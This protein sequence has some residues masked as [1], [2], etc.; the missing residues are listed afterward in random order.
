MDRKAWGLVVLLAAAGCSAAGGDDG[1]PDGDASEAGDRG[2]SRP[3][4][5]E[6]PP[7]TPPPDDDDGDTIADIDE[8]RAAAVD[9]DRDG[10][11]DYLDLDSDDDTI[12]DSEEAGDDDPR[13]APVD[14]DGDTTPDFRDPDSDGDG[15]SDRDEVAA[16]TDRLRADTDDDGVSDMI[17]VAAGTDPLD[18][19]DNPRA[20]GNFVFVVPYRE[21]PEPPR[22]TLV[23]GTDIQMADVYFAIDR[24]ASMRA[25]LDNL[26]STLRGTI[27]PRVD[28][29]IPDVWF[30]VGTFDQCPMR[31]VCTSSGTPVW[32]RN[33]QNLA[34]DPAATQAALDAMSGTCN[35]ASEPYVST[36]WLLAN[37]DPAR[38]GWDPARV[39]PRNCP[40]AGT[41]IGYP[42]FRAGAIPIV[43]MFGDEDFY[44]QSN[45]AGCNPTTGDAPAVADAIA[46]MNRIGARFIGINSGSS[47]AGFE[48][49]ARGT[50][51]I[52]G[53]GNPLVFTIPGDG[54]GLGDQLAGA[55]ERLASQTPMD[56]S[57]DAVDVAEGP[58]DTVDATI[59][60]DRI[61]PNAAGGV[62]DPRNPAR[63]C[64]GG[65]PVADR[66][67]DTH[68]DV[69][70]GVRPGTIVCFDIIARRNETVRPAREALV[71]RAQVR[72]IGQGITVLDRRDVYF[73]VPPEIVVVPIE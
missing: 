73:L 41:W 64:V 60:I 38:W 70:P 9:T 18:A 3:D 13:T 54:T 16:G 20:R 12:P 66:D 44:S 30:G 49:V 36:V 69:F 48:D 43:V 65:L 39:A 11:P 71:F 46:E 25:E 35:G 42:C 29:A 28:A 32:I 53:A 62:A 34:G 6:I 67:S 63:I 72:V 58:W 5:A 59:F 22:D 2:D 40:A 26:R 33:L 56:V 4:T 37:G 27:V 47:R 14:T 45:G 7:D 52:D 8:G 10:T 50:G 51:S 17:E 1:E 31:G 24:S 61:V 68:P 21:D 55:I 23:F 15:L 19:S 57:A